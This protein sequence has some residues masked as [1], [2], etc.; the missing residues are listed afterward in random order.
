MAIGE[1]ANGFP[2]AS[3][4][5]ALISRR[6]RNQSVNPRTAYARTT[7]RFGS[8]PMEYPSGRRKW[9]PGSV[10][11]ASE[12]ALDR[13]RIGRELIA[14]LE[15]VGDDRHSR[16]SDLLGVGAKGVNDLPRCGFHRF[17]GH[18]VRT[19][20]DLERAA[21]DRCDARA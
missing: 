16:N 10:G 4:M 14:P 9:H 20:H 1:S 5:T 12:A 19:K 18:A 2:R 11:L 13:L 8:T 7:R 6:V 21:E 17:I 3:S 15:N